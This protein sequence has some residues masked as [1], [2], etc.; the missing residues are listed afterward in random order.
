M[1]DGVSVEQLRID[2]Y[3]AKVDYL[4][5]HFNRMWTRFNF[6]LTIE[7]VALSALAFSRDGIEVPPIVAVLGAAISF[8]WWMFGREDKYLVDLYRAQIEESHEALN[9]DLRGQA[10]RVIGDTRRKARDLFE[11]RELT[12]ARES[13]E[14]PVNPLW[15]WITRG[16]TEAL[17]ITRLP[18]ALPA[19]LI[20]VWLAIGAA[21]TIAS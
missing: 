1:S 18:A 2:D 13:C 6:F 8:V 5:N 14:R 15:N 10:P 19:F 9:S 7:G 11:A 17:S 3:F 20:V 4:V 12:K 16:R 21:G